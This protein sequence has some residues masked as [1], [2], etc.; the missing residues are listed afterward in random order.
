MLASIIILALPIS[1]IGAN[2]TQ[3][4]IVFKDQMKMKEQAHKLKP[5]FV[6][7]VRSLH[8][9]NCVMEELLQEIRV[10]ET[11]MTD[12]VALI[13]SKLGQQV[14]EDPRRAD[15]KHEQAR[16]EPGRLGMCN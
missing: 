11:N 13:R 3:Q 2:F 5:C 10:I 15:P 16:R 8:E 7:M 12:T 1:V 9:H 14:T 6:D 4:W